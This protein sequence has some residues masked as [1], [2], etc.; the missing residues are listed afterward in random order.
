MLKGDET[1]EKITNSKNLI[2]FHLFTS[3]LEWGQIFQFIPE[4]EF[5]NYSEIISTERRKNLI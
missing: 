3:G 1:N 2:K 4:N 5:R